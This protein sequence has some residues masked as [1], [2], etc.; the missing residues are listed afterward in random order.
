VALS[1]HVVMLLTNWNDAPMSPFHPLRPAEVLI[2]TETPMLG[3][4]RAMG[5][6]PTDWLVFDGYTEQQFRSSGY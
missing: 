2:W 6:M 4:M 1:T 5:D 3:D